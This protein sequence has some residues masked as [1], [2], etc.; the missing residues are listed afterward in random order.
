MA[1]DFT[2]APPEPPPV[3]RG[4]PLIAWVVI[5]AAAVG[6]FVLRLHFQRPPEVKKFD[7]FEIQARCAGRRGQR[8]AVGSRPSTSR[9]RNLTTARPGSGCAS[10]CWL[11]SCA[12]RT[13]R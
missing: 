7:T 8:R 1:T 11:G 5:I 12:G 9:P 10:S 4:H 3:P 13:R 2:D 6:L